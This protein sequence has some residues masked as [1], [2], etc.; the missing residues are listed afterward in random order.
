[1][2]KG[3]IAGLSAVGVAVILIAG[4]YGLTLSKLNPGLQQA[5][6]NVANYIN[7]ELGLSEREAV[8][9]DLFETKESGLFS[10]QYNLVVATPDSNNLQIP[11]YVDV[12]YLSYDF[13]V[14]LKNA[15]VG[16]KKV[17]ETYR[18][19]LDRL[20]ELDLTGNAHLLTGSGEVNFVVKGLNDFSKAHVLATNYDE[21]KNFRKNPAAFAKDLGYR[22]QGEMQVSVTF[23][24]DQEINMTG[25]L[26]SFIADEFAVGDMNFSS[27]TKG[28]GSKLSD[29]GSLDLVASS[30]FVS[31]YRESHSVDRLKLHSQATPFDNQGNFDLTTKLECTGIDN[32]I[33]Q[34]TVEAEVKG[35]NY[36]GLIALNNAQVFTPDMLVNY[37]KRYPF[38]FKILPSTKLSYVDPETQKAIEFTVNGQAQSLDSERIEG[39]LEISANTDLTKIPALDLVSGAFVTK[40]DTSKSNLSFKLPFKQ[41]RAQILLNGDP[42]F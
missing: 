2:S 9:V 6:T 32:D 10:R 34:A 25:K 42:V 27:R 19:E 22:D 13:S 15:E 20:T 17:F 21:L 8:S 12:N 33:T 16:G 37:L 5:E 14:D 29:L 3:K 4:G 38:D 41:G 39:N 28:F 35:L 1:M 23:N 26:S 24:R 30:L 36:P 7:K 31:Q 18:S 11:V 40:G